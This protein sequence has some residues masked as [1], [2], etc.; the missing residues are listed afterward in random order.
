[1]VRFFAPESYFGLFLPQIIA[2]VLR[3]K[4]VFSAF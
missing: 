1:V 2:F 3:Q 4:A